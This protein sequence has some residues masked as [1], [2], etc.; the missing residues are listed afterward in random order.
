ME[1]TLGHQW[2]T[3]T[4]KPQAPVTDTVTKRELANLKD[5]VNNSFEE[6]SN[7]FLELQQ[8]LQLIEERLAKFNERSSH[9]L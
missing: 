3:Q 2:T 6:V 1:G 8:G 7:M 5:Q 4:S 9:K